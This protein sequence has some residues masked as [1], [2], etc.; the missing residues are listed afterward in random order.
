MH[1]CDRMLTNMLLMLLLS[2][3]GEMLLLSRG[4][5]RETRSNNNS[6]VDRYL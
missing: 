6:T 5:E 1:Y 2:R 4:G 3:G